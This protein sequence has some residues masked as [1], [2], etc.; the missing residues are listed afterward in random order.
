MLIGGLTVK[1]KRV[2]ILRQHIGTF[3]R[4]FS[5]PLVVFLVFHTI[6]VTNSV[7]CVN[8]V[9]YNKSIVSGILFYSV[10]VVSLSRP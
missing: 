10:S 3:S 1:D 2:T 9:I 8:F 4:I 5:R 7:T 6:C